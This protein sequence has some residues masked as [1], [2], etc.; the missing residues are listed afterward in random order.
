MFDV[1]WWWAVLK[2]SSHLYLVHRM[3]QVTSFYHDEI[4]M[5]TT[6][7]STGERSSKY[8]QPIQCLWNVSYYMGP[9]RT[10]CLTKFESSDHRGMGWWTEQCPPVHGLTVIS[11]RLPARPITRTGRLLHTAKKKSTDYPHWWITRT[12]L[13]NFLV[14]KT[15][16]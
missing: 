13:F 4:L 1:V 15:W 12:L 14:A 16:H 6:D 2:N 5:F 3:C 10:N 9:L 11:G 8:F 7:P